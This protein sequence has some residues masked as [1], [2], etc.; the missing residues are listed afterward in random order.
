[1]LNYSDSY[2]HC[3]ALI[4][5]LAFFKSKCSLFC[6]QWKKLCEQVDAGNPS[7]ELKEKLLKDCEIP[8]VEMD[9]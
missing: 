7:E 5:C 2:W 3:M 4:S 9:E 8:S 1:M 6:F